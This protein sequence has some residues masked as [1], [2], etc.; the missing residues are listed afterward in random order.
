MRL[1]KK[2]EYGLIVE[3][4]EYVSGYEAK[5]RE[6]NLYGRAL[7]EM[8][9]DYSIYDNENVLK[10]YNEYKKAGSTRKEKCLTALSTVAGFS[11][12]LGIYFYESLFVFVPLS[13]ALLVIPLLYINEK[14]NSGK[15]DKASKY[16]HIFQRTLIEDMMQHRE[17]YVKKQVEEDYKIIESITK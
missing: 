9:K 13:F 6:G 11:F 8:A 14:Y 10:A 1:R 12:I 4:I 5:Y 17:P 3:A 7:R 15:Y 16:K 2:R